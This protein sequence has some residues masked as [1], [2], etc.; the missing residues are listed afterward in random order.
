MVSYNPRTS[1]PGVIGS[2]KCDVDSCGGSY[3]PMHGPLCLMQAEA[4]RLGY[5][6]LKASDIAKE[7]R[8]SDV[9]ALQEAEVGLRCSRII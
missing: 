9:W 3:C 8:I 7:G 1:P 6:R 2:S 4:K 5:V